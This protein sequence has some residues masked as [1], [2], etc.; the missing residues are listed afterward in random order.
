MEDEAPDGP[1][2]P[3]TE[4]PRQASGPG[5]GRNV[6]ERQHGENG[7]EY[8]N[9]AGAAIAQ[10]GPGGAE[11]FKDPAGDQEAQGQ[12]EGQDG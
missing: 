2:K 10:Q 9:E 6:E 8:G 3:L 11:L 5:N 4:Q 1:G 7:S 12:G